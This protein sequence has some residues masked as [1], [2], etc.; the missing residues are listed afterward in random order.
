MF[1][2]TYKTPFAFFAF[3]V[4]FS[5]GQS[6]SGQVIASSGFDMN[7]DGWTCTAPQNI[8][9][10]DSGGNPG[11]FL[12]FHDQTYYDG[13]VQAPAK[14]FGNWAALDNNGILSFDHIIIDKGAGAFV[15][16]HY[17]VSIQGPGGSASWAG[18]TPTDADVGIWK[19]VIVPIQKSQWVVGSGD[20]A[21]ILANVT[22]VDIGIEMV[23]NNG[24]FDTDGL[25]NI[26]LYKPVTVSI[27]GAVTLEACNDPEQNI[28]F[29]FRPKPSG[30]PFKVKQVLT[31]SGPNI[32]TFSLPN[33]PVG[34]YDIAIKGYS[35]L[36]K[37]I[38]NV[39]VTGD[40]S[41]ATVLLPVG[42]LNNDNSVDA[43]D[44]GLLVGTYN[45]VGD[46]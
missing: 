35:W 19:H 6:A 14:Y 10:S 46:L 12:K 15:F 4:L 17:R 11:G 22:R 21:T 36:Q 20:W 41:V 2:R 25:D 38:P 1:S 8:F 45:Q 28:T 43:T 37:V 3:A 29:E 9:W 34:T 23:G 16:N 42:D 31:Q 44:F 13:N 30:T 27:S 5:Y 26:Q 39:V 24:G 32:G 40:I 7:L 18:L 33:I